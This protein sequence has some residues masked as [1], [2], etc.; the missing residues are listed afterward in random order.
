MKHY[1]TERSCIISECL[2]LKIHVFITQYFIMV[3]IAQ[4][5]EYKNTLQIE[6]FII[7]ILAIFPFIL[8]LPGSPTIAVLD[9]M[10]FVSGL[11]VQAW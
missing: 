3:T 6:S 1:K 8:P 4:I 10:L 11:L 2:S 7:M 9:S 5:N